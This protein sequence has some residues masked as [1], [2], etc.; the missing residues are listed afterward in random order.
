[1]SVGRRVPEAAPVVGLLLGLS[2]AV[3]ALLF[4]GAVLVAVLVAVTLTYAFTAW[5]VYHSPDPAAVLLPDPVFAGAGLVGALAV[6]YAVVTGG[7]VLFGLFVALVVVV[8]AALYHARY[9]EPLNPLSPLGTLVA[10]GVLAAGVLAVGVLVDD[11]LLAAV[12]AALVVLAAEDYRSRRGDP[13]T[14][15]AERAAVAVCIGGAVLSVAYFLLVAGTPAAAVVVAA[16]FVVMGAYFAM[17]GRG[18]G[19]G[20][21]RRR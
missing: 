14:R 4:T 10:A 6:G 15:A 7:R 20:S 16:A 1:M 12:D 18:Y 5:A 19:S 3:Y 11:P 8:P 2:F 17:N 9:G 21:R 13:L